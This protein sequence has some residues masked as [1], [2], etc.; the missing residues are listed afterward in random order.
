V[1]LVWDEAAWDDCIWWQQQ[2]RE[3][4]KRINAL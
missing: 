1:K 2:D 3:V 4:L